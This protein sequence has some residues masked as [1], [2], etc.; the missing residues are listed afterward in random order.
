[1]KF[2]STAIAVLAI[3]LFAACERLPGEIN[4]AKREV[5]RI[6][7]D[8][9]SAKFESVYINKKSGAVC[10][11][12]N[13]RNRMGGYTGSSPFVY[14]K[15]RGLI[16]VQESPTERDFERYFENLRHSDIEEY[17]K[18]EE[19][20][21]SIFTWGQKCEMESYSNNNKYC[22]LINA[23]KTFSDLYKLVEPGYK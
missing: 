8:P 22:K 15:S 9:D 4:E 23:G 2:K 21:V 16:M 5:R 10:G 18:L 6:L 17:N 7:I 19:R 13:A 14:E 11:Y 1:M 20:C 12:V 3:G